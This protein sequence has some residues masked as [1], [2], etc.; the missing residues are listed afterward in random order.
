MESVLGVALGIAVGVLL[1]LLLKL[2]NLAE[3]RDRWQNDFERETRRAQ[4]AQWRLEQ[5]EAALEK[6]FPPPPT[7][8]E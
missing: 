6:H 3:E 2:A 8:A 4:A 7:R 5:V 1:I